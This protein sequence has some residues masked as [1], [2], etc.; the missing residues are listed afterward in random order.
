MKIST[1]I[2]TGFRDYANYDNER[3]LP[4]LMD[5]LK[6]TERKILWA[7][8][9]HIG[10]HTLVVDKAGMRAADLSDYHHGATS[11]IGVLVNMNRDYP[12]TNNLPLFDKD[13][14][15]GTRLKKEASSPRYISTK[16][17]AAYKKLF[18]AN[19]NLILKKQFSQDTGAEIE[20]LY[21]LPKLPLLLINGSDGTGN[22]YSSKVLSYDPEEIK[23]AVEEVLKTGLVQNKLTPCLNG[24]IGAIA[25]DHATG[26]VTFEGI[27][28]RKGANTIIIK[29]LPP[30]YDLSDYKEILNLLMTE[31][32]GPHKDQP[33][34]IKDYDNESTEDGWRFVVDVPRTTAQMTDEE[35]LQKFKLIERQTENLT[36]WIPDGRLKKYSNVESLIE[37]WV[38]YRLA[39]YEARRQDQ[40]NRYNVELD[41]LQTKLK[42]INW[43]NYNSTNLITLTKSE[44]QERT[45]KNITT[46]QDYI[47]RLLSIRISN[48]GLEEVQELELEI[49]KLKKSVAEL[50]ATTAKKIMTQELKGLKL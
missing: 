5:G 49:A 8:V 36:V 7:F 2:D 40:I 17:G 19:D 41:W 3:S 31:K 35:L 11:M 24:Y 23:T 12:G 14:Q 1:F 29:E 13:G 30:K 50:E 43:W 15:F 28:E 9:E 48:L 32:T 6:I 27:I 10:N 33:P 44:L 26:Q 20:P 42:F 46:N 21:Y 37:D 25:K 38:R 16:L 45:V 39:A 34:L 4:H 18:D 47:I 22:G